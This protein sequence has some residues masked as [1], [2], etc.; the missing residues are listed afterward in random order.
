[1]LPCLVNRRILAAAVAVGLS[2]GGANQAG[3]V[4][5]PSGGELCLSERKV[6]LR[7]DEG[8]IER[9]VTFTIAPTTDLPEA[10]LG[11]GFEI[12]PSGTTFLKPAHVTFRYDGLPNIDDDAGVPSTLLRVY[13]RDE[14]GWV[15][16]SDPQLDR[17]RGTVGG[18]VGHLSPFVLLRA[19]RLPDGG[20]PIEGDA[21]LMKDGGPIIVPPR[22]DAGRDSGVQ[23][24]GTPDAGRKDGGTPDA[25]PPDAGPP[26]AGPPDAGPPDAGP[27]DAG[28]PDAG[29]PDAGPP[30]A[31]PAD[32]GPPDAGAP[33]AGDD[34]GISDAGDG[35]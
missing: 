27:P 17:V 11:D 19:D 15:P 5:T 10:A 1:M 4:L 8:A 33:D 29:P 21:G 18:T 24:S 23:D 30:D 3:G 13:T 6:C 31:G 28:P 25:G 22:P 20:L 26:D 32:A 35:G 34:A 7:L 14:T 2:C 16:L 9:Q 12:G